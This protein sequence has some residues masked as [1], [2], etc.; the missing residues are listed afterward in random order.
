MVRGDPDNPAG[1]A[2]RAAATRL[3]ELVPPAEDETCTARI[4]RLVEALDAQE[5]QPA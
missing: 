3:V 2:I 1:I 4:A 5:R